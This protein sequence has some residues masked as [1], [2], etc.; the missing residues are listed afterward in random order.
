MG[1]HIPPYSIPLEANTLFHLGIL[2]NTKIARD[3]P[4][5]VSLAASKIKFVGSDAPSIP[6]NWRFAE[7][8]SSLKALEGTLLSCLLLKKYGISP[9]EIVIDTDHAQ[10]FIMSTLIWAIDPKGQNL[11]MSMDEESM[12]KIHS[13]FP[14]KYRQLI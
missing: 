3:L 9:R 11:R 1:S 10:L 4:A 13:Y 14:S 8:I 7:S 5:E 2:Q 6:I 12:K